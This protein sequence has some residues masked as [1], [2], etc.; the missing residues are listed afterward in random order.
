[1]NHS[2]IPHR[3]RLNTEPVRLF[4]NRSAAKTPNWQVT[5][6]STRMVVLP[7][8]NGTVSFAVSTGHNSGTVDRIEK[9]MANMPAK[10]MSS[11]ESHTI[12]PTETL[13]GRRSAGCFVVGAAR[14]EEH[15]SE[16]QSRC[17]LVCR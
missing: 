13:L 5:E 6:L 12:V 1:M 11:L 2:C 9:Y 7:M 16:L 3:R 8:T 14:S 10:N 17:Q 4:W 15:T